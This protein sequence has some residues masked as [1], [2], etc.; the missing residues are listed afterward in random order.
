MQIQNKTLKDH[1]NSWKYNNISNKN[2]D[3]MMMGANFD[4]NCF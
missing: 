3:K 2:R 1:N 4:N